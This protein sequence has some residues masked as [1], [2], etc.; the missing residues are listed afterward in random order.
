MNTV[1]IP[2]V[3]NHNDTYTWLFKTVQWAVDNC[4]SFRCDE[5]LDSPEVTAHV[6]NSC[7]LEPYIVRDPKD[8]H[9]KFTFEDD[10]DAMLFALRWA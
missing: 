7:S 6:L 10:R 5:P 9:Y 4:S 2:M 8:F 1:K 3:L